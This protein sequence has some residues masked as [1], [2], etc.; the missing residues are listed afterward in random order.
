MTF[1]RHINLHIR[2]YLHKFIRASY[3]IHFYFV[4]NS[5]QQSGWWKVIHCDTSK[6]QP[7]FWRDIITLFARNYLYKCNIEILTEVYFG[8]YMYRC[9]YTYLILYL[10]KYRSYDSNRVNPSAQFHYLA[11]IGNIKYSQEYSYPS[12]WYDV[13]NVAMLSYK[14]FSLDS[15]L[16]FYWFKALRRIYEV[17][18]I[19]I[20]LWAALTRESRC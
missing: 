15:L 18:S 1:W 19:L 4:Q 9:A 12:G 16:H 6:C 13:A 20:Q 14:T 3:Y 11:Q 8:G 2:T 7:V 10:R 17:Y 5:L